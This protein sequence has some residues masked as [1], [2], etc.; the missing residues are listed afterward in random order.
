MLIVLTGPAS[1]GKDTAA[2]ELLKIY[3]GLKRVVSTTTRPKRPGEMEGR[4]YHFVTKEEFEKMIQNQDML[5]YVDFSGN[6][7][8]TTKK[9]L[10]PLYHGQD[11]LWRVETSRA[12]KIN[13]VLPES[14]G[15]KTIVIYIDVPDWEIL[16]KRMR[17]R[18]MTEAEITQR[19]NQDESDFQKY[20]SSFNHIIYNEE[21]KIKETLDRIKKLIDE[22]KS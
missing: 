6:Y 17:K 11:L 21:G 7:Y 9:E 5:E 2:L 3:S 15:G 10:K 8:G 18:G 19:L 12:A 4:D 16:K 14:L 1:A 20:K 22:N 13:E